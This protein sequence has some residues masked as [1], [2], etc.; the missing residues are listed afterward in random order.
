[1]CPDL[2]SPGRYYEV[3]G[4]LRI[5]RA[6]LTEAGDHHPRRRSRQLRLAMNPR[7]ECSESTR[8]GPAHRT[9]ANAD[10]LW[11]VEKELAVAVRSADGAAVLGRLQQDLREIPD[12]VAGIV[13][14]T[15]MGKA[16]RSPLSDTGWRTAGGARGIAIH[17]RWAFGAGVRCHRR[18]RRAG[19]PVVVASGS[20]LGRAPA[21]GCPKGAERGATITVPERRTA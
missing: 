17:W 7:H 10:I 18:D 16:V 13:Q 5:R 2:Q 8:D 4:P 21:R 19:E 20:L 11:T 14:D 9:N 3:A 6:L 1:M 12:L 15:T